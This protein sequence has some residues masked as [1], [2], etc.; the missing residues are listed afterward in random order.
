MFGV[1]AFLLF[2]RLLQGHR[3][4]RGPYRRSY[5]RSGFGYPPVIVVP[6]GFGRDGGG[7]WGSGGFAGGGGSSGGGGASG[8]W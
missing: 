7:G 8:S 1:I 5:S 3:A 4:P 6:S 2:V